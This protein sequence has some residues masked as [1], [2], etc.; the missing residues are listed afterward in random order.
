MLNPRFIKVKQGRIAVAIIAVCS[1]K[2]GVGKT[3]LAVDL[4]WRSAVAGKYRTLLWDLDSQGGAGFLLGH[5]EP[6]VPRAAG[7]FQRDGK[8]RQLIEPTAYPGLS[9]LPG[10]TSLRGLPGALARLGPKRLANIAGFLRA[11]FD[12]II[13]DCPAGYNELTEQAIMAADLL[14]VPLPPSP[15]S[16]RS[17]DMLRRDILRVHHRHP[18]ILP[19]LSMYSSRRMLHRTVRDGDAAGWPVIPFA[20]LI[21]QMAVRRAPLGAFSPHVDAARALARLW[22]GIETKLA[23]RKA[24]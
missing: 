11:D 15:L 24:A 20:S 14:I 1:V 10:D 3:T 5:D 18:P 19:V 22:H 8:P 23:T 16:A 7:I 17:L 6:R 12:R 21:E 2:G 13:L 4:A 9:L